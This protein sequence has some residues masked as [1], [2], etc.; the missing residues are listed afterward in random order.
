MDKKVLELLENFDN[1]YTQE[2]LKDDIVFF[3]ANGYLKALFDLAESEEVKQKIAK[4]G[5]HMTLN[6][7]LKD[8]IK[9]SLG[10]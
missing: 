6:S 2:Q 7:V 3:E 5:L 1:I 10:L 4:K 8:V 9:H